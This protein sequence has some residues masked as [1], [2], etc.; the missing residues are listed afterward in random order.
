MVELEMGPGSISSHSTFPVSWQQRISCIHDG[1][2]TELAKPDAA[3]APL[4]LPD[5]TVTP[6]LG[7]PWGVDGARPPVTPPPVELGRD[8]AAFLQTFGG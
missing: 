1:I 8:T 2:D 5:G 7:L 4:T 6:L 3:V